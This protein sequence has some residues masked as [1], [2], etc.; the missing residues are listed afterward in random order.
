MRIILSA[1]LSK[2]K[3]PA[4]PWNQP[5]EFGMNSFIKLENE[6]FIL[7][8]FPSPA[9]NLWLFL[10]LSALV[11]TYKRWL[12]AHD[13]QAPETLSGNN[14]PEKA[15]EQHPKQELKHWNEGGSCPESALI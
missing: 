1:S 4:F 7:L 12:A 14:G 3:N 9:Y 5:Q 10:K 2:F 13:K 15:M 11:L 6:S 8:F